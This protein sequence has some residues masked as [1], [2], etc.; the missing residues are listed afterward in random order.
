MNKKQFFI[1]MKSASKFFEKYSLPEVGTVA[2]STEISYDMSYLTPFF[3]K[4]GCQPNFSYNINTVELMQLEC[5]G[6]LGIRSN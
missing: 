4:A 6:G 2:R 1:L 3:S 5:S